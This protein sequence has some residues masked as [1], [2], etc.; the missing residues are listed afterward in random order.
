MTAEPILAFFLL[1]YLRKTLRTTSIFA[2]WDKPLTYAMI[3]IAILFV[4]ERIFSVQALIIWVWHLIIL[5]IIG[6]SFKK[7][8]LHPARST[9]LA[10]LPLALVF[11]LSDLIK[12]LPN[13]LYEAI[14]DYPDFAIPFA[15]IWMVAML[16]ISRKQRK[17]LE[18]ERKK[19]HEEE[20]QNRIMA[21]RKAELEILVAERTSEIMQQKNELEHALIELR[22]TQA[23]LIQAEKMASLGEL[24]A[25]IAHEIQNPLNFVNNFSEVNAELIE[26]LKKELDTGNKEEAVIIFPKDLPCV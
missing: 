14:K 16:I 19:T 25:G 17:A 6:I 11:F 8:E 20:E 4:L 22:T 10:V 15:V 18:S 9:M 24:T 26:E 21:A 2:R 7:D 23:Q 3:G 13:R 5:L 12:L 1:R